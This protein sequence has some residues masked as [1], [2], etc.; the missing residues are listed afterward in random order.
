MSDKVR[1][2]DDFYLTAFKIKINVGG[3]FLFFDF[4][5][6]DCLN[7]EVLAILQFKD[8]ENFIPIHIKDKVIYK[9]ENKEYEI[10]SYKDD[11]VFWL[12]ENND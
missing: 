2:A 4:E 3:R 6:Y 7:R 1:L 10:T 8:S 11:S 12:V 9:K 5:P